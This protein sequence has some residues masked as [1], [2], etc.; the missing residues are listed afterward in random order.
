MTDETGQSTGLQNTREARVPT[1]RAVGQDAVELYEFGPF[2]LDPAER[3]LSRNDEPVVLTPKA[4]DTLVLLVRN[5]GH[6]LAKDELLRTLWP[7]SFVEEGNLSNNIFILR[8]SLGEDPQYIETVPKRGYRF[9]GAARQLPIPSVRDEE[10]PQSEFASP[11]AQGAAV[12]AAL[13]EASSTRR[14]RSEAARLRSRKLAGWLSAGT[15]CIVL[16]TLIYRNWLPPKPDEPLAAVPLTVLPG[17]ADFPAISPDGSR[18]VFEWTGEQNFT[19]FDL[20]VKTI[21][22]ETLLRLTKDPA[23]PFNESRRTREVF[24]LFPP[25]AELS[26]SCAPQMHRSIVR[27]K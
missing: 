5:S 13:S 23:L 3:K 8:K 11:T 12:G 18:V 7:D 10:Q 6:L 24:T 17:L 20:Y 4:F 22:N 15:L 26:G 16:G 2:R 25:K 19:A 1:T 14:A 9:V 27:C 21:G